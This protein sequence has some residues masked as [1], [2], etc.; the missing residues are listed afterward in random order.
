MEEYGWMKVL[1]TTTVGDWYRSRNRRRQRFYV[2]WVK[3]WTMSLSLSSLMQ[4]LYFALC[5]RMVDKK[6]KLWEGMWEGKH[7]TTKG[8][9]NQFKN[10]KR[11][12]LLYLKEILKLKMKKNWE[13]WSDK[14]S[15]N[16]EF[17]RE[18]IFRKVFRRK[19]TNSL[20]MF[21]LMFYKFKIL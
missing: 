10:C 16:L 3:S 15:S 4:C 17:V 18:R 1:W 12:Y 19:S 2:D 21:I 7:E 9:M 14:P 5:S 20:T 8:N 13:S 11:K 6:E